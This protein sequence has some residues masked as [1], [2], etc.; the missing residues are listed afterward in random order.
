MTSDRNLP[1]RR[2][3]IMPRPPRRNI[4]TQSQ[5]IPDRESS[6][7]QHSQTN[8]ALVNP[9]KWHL[10]ENTGEYLRIKYNGGNRVLV[11]TTPYGERWKESV[12]A[13]QELLKLAGL[14]VGFLIAGTVLLQIAYHTAAPD[15]VF[16][17]SFA[18]VF[19][20]SSIGPFFLL[21]AGLV[22]EGFRD[23]GPEPVSQ[24]PRREQAERQ[25]VH[26][27]GRFINREEIDRAA[28]GEIA[29]PGGEQQ[30][31]D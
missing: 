26:G 5:R 4:Q 28:S 11:D 15:C 8:P 19:F 7:T 30:Y 16:P 12:L 17:G 25:H 3:L 6:A 13:E 18:I 22:K 31:E 9:R 29:F 14:T 2:D 1:I 27:D 10:D 20:L 23:L 24:R 21:V